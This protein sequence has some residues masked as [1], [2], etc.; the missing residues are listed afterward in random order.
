MPKKKSAEGTTQE[1]IDR[2]GV[3]MPLLQAMLTEFEGFA[4]KKPDATLNSTKVVTVNRIIG[5][6]LAILDGEPGREYLSLLDEDALPQNS[7]VTLQLRLVIAAMKAFKSR[8]Y[9]RDDYD[10]W[11]WLLK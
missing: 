2:H 8:Y 4:K 10:E 11:N 5:D 9:V 7:D 3:V 6:S 1:K